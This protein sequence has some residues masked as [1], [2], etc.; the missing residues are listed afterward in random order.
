MAIYGSI[1]RDG[2]RIKSNVWGSVSEIRYRMATENNE[3]LYEL[4]EPLYVW[5]SITAK[6]PVGILIIHK[7]NYHIQYWV[8][9]K[10]YYYYALPMSAHGK[11]TLAKIVDPSTIRFIKSQIKK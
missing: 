4:G 2:K 5:D 10:G 7:P 3:L 6:D 9:E 8:T 1:G 11:G